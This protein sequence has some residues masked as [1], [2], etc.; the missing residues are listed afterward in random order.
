MGVS[1]LWR[2]GGHPGAPAGTAQ[3]GPDINELNKRF[4]DVWS[5]PGDHAS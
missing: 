4:Y 3:S 2:G 1:G 5:A